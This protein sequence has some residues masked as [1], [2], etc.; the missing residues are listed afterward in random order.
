VDLT[1]LDGQGP[2]SSSDLLT[3]FPLQNTNLDSV[4]ELRVTRLWLSSNESFFQPLRQTFS[5]KDQSPIDP[6]RELKIN[7]RLSLGMEV[8][9]R[10]I[11]TTDKVVLYDNIWKYE[12]GSHVFTEWAA[13]DAQPFAEE[14]V[15]AYGELANQIV[16]TI[17]KSPLPE[18]E[19]DMVGK[20]P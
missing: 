8:R 17:S 14:F 16:D 19:G 2:E 12:G 4:L 7:P 9:G 6:Y 1:V 18:G 3:Y 5:D 10:L 20:S 15:K 11:R 13:N